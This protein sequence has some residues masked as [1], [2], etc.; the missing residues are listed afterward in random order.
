METILT[1]NN[2]SYHYQSGGKRQAILENANYDFTAGTFYT[3]LGPSGSGKTTMLSISSGLDVPNE[4]QVL[5]KKQSL[6]TSLSLQ[7][8]RKN[9]CAIIFQAYNLIPYMTALQNVITAI[10]IQH[11]RMKNKRAHAVKML[12]EVGLTP[13]QMKRP[14]LQ[15]SGGQQQRVTIARA[16]SGSAQI[17]FADEPTGNLDGETADKII[18]LFKALAHQMDKCIIMVTHDKAIAKESDITLTLKNKQ[19]VEVL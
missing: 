14:V 1:L 2:I 13:E 6:G 8:Y 16:L 19:L 17:I 3:I 11:P 7:K 12:T 10:G 18:Y 4:G 9:H 15:L 5:Y